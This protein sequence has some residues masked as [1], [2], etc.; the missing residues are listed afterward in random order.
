MKIYFTALFLC[1]CSASVG[2]STG[3]LKIIDSLHK[4][5]IDTLIHYYQKC[6]TMWGPSNEYLLWRQK[7]STKIMTYTSNE[8]EKEKATYTVR[9]IIDDTIFLYLNN[10]FTKIISDR[11]YPCIYKQ[12]MGDTTVYS[13]MEH[14]HPCHVFFYFSIKGMPVG[15]YYLKEDLEESPY[16]H[17]ENLNYKFNSSTN[18]FHLIKMVQKVAQ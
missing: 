15:N 16:D 7:S 2:Q 9:T 18:L 13:V 14:L 4:K 11:I 10:H 6:E 3:I 12:Q 1:I 5:N 17:F 8:L